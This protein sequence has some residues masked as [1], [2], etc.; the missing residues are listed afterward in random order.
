MGRVWAFNGCLEEKGRAFVLF[1]G[2]AGLDSVADRDYRRRSS[3]LV[4]LKIRPAV[5][6]DGAQSIACYNDI[7]Q[8]QRR[9]RDICVGYTHTKKG[10]K[11]MQNSLVSPTQTKKKKKTNFK[12]SSFLCHVSLFLPLPLS[13]CTARHGIQFHLIKHKGSW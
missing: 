7:T 6:T 10:R 9:S 5:D 3:Y 11:W 8:Q 4:R 2:R 13:L 12:A 1:T